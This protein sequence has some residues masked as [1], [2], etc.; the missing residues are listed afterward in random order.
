MSILRYLIQDFKNTGRQNQFFDFIRLKTV[1][2][3]TEN[4]FA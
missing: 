4:P 2:Y 1:K 3:I